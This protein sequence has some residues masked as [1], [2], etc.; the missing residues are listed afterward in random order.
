MAWT[1]Y[2]VRPPLSLK[3]LFQWFGG[4][5]AH[6]SKEIWITFQKVFLNLNSDFCKLVHLSLFWQLKDIS[7]EGT[8]CQR[9]RWRLDYAQYTIASRK[10]LQNT[11]NHSLCL[12]KAETVE[13][14][15]STIAKIIFE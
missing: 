7:K 6:L 9:Q 8:Y 14:V 5:S 12:F 3:G 1:S 2:T 11:E 10:P 13:A 4:K 15:K